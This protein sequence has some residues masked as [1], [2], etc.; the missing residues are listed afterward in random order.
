M[1][2]RMAQHLLRAIL[3]HLCHF[4]DFLIVCATGFALYG[5]GLGTQSW[6]ARWFGW[7]IV[8]FGGNSLTVHNWHRLG[9]WA[10]VL[11]VMVHLYTAIREDIMSKQSMVSTIIS[12][13]RMFKD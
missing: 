5:E 6:A 2:L 9:M 1:W 12:G 11:F 10:I 8:A 4:K 3:L 13:F 7:I